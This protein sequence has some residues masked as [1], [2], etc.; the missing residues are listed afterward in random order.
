MKKKI[1][2]L[3]ILTLLIALAPFGIYK[4]FYPQMPQK[5]PTHYSMGGVADTF[6]NK[7]SYDVLIICGFGLIGMLFMKGTELLIVK[8]SQLDKKQK[9][10]INV[11]K[12]I[13]GVSTFLVTILFSSI[14]IYFLIIA[15]GVYKFKPTDLFE[16]MNV[17]LGILFIILGNYMP[18]LKQNSLSGFRT[19][20]TLSDE[21]VWFKTQRFAGK[22]WIIGGI[23]MIIVS[24]ASA[25]ASYVF[26]L[27]L[28]IIFPIIV[29]ILPY[30]YSSKIADNIKNT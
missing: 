22:V 14:T 11:V 13:M 7:S 15:T 20:H 4:Y 19:K 26:S 5:I 16:M 25:N 8:C 28:G 3:F 24:A 10:N 2:V 21:N 18:K 23:I 9:T 30:V 1:N 17:I 12:H 27:S 29:V 6:T